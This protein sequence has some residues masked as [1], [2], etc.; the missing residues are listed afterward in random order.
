[1]LKKCEADVKIGTSISDSKYSYTNPRLGR[2]GI[3]PVS[4]M[5]SESLFREPVVG[6]FCGGVARLRQNF[7]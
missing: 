6:L 7:E 1:M 3:P 5:K 2:A 4:E